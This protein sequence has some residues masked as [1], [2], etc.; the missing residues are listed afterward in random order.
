MVRKLAHE[1]AEVV[2]C[3]GERTSLEI[4]WNNKGEACPFTFLS[5]GEA[6]A[7]DMMPLPHFM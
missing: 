2:K 5:L 6:K 1:C 3:T 4:G 7:F